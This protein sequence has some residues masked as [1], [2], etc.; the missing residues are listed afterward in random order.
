MVGELVLAAGLGLVRLLCLRLELSRPN[1]VPL[2]GQPLLLPRTAQTDLTSSST[3]LDT[4]TGVQA[5][6]PR[7]LQ[8][9]AQGLWLPT[10]VRQA[11]VAA[12]VVVAGHL[13]V[14]QLP[15]LVVGEVPV[16]L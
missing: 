3:G 14:A 5:G 15:A 7:M 12:G 13:R 2:V 11:L 1:P 6:V 16:K 4:A 10:A 8:L 9:L